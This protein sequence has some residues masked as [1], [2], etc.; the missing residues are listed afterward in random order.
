MPLCLRAWILP[1]QLQI[2]RHDRAR[3]LPIEE[4]EE[5]LVIGTSAGALLD[6]VGNTRKMDR[7]PPRHQHPQSATPD[8]I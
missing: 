8:R 7:A 5:S 3:T 1:P 4:H 6:I 2:F